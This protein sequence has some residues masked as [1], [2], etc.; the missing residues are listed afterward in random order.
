MPFL[1][2][3][4]AAVVAVTVLTSCTTTGNPYDG[5]A[6]ASEACQYDYHAS[7]TLGAVLG[8]V[9]GAAAAGRRDQAAGVLV[10]AVIGGLLAYVATSF[11]EKRCRA[12]AAARAKMVSTSLTY[13]PVRVSNA[14]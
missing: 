10:G 3:T 14:S 7:T 9:A 2:R 11:L 13:V 12:L 8:G 1:L 4:A 6:G 5:H